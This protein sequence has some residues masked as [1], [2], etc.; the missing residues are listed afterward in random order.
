MAKD[1]D[2]TDIILEQLISMGGEGET[3]SRKLLRPFI[4]GDPKIGKT[5]LVARICV[6]LGLKPMW[7]YSD[8]GI[9]TLDKF[10]ELAA[11][12]R[13]IPYD[14]LTQVRLI[15]KA[16]EEGV[17]PFCNYDTLVWDTVSTAINST[18]RALVREKPLGPKEQADPDLEGWGHYRLAEA[19][20]KDTVA[21]LTKSGMH[22]FYIAH[23]RDPNDK[24]K[25]KKRFAIR[26]AGPEATYR[27]IAQEAN[28]IGWLYKD[29]GKRK[30]DLVGSL[31]VTA[32]TQIP[33]LA[34]KLYPV[35]E[36]PKLLA[37]YVNS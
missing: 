34:E 3:G 13:F 28:L 30:L 14:G 37:K 36:I 1:P 26:P 19:N 16:R 27:V 31:Q 5:D 33:T 4:Y 12:T 7:F 29:Q 24:D 11:R 32:G 20:M 18:L 10:P 17:E 9:S 2:L 25:E 15:T 6:E 22:V 35:E 23:I 8:S 21:K